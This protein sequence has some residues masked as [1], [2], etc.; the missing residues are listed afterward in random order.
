[1][2]LTG[3]NNKN[4]LHEKISVEEKDFSLESGKISIKS[5]M[6]G[7][8]AGKSGNPFIGVG[9]ESVTLGLDK[10]GDGKLVKNSTFA[11]TAFI[12][13][14]IAGQVSDNYRFRR[15]ENACF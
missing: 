1:M 11:G 9:N 8:L 7:S 3:E 2:K 5:R 14:P 12:F 4:I 15:I 6:V 10:R 13:I